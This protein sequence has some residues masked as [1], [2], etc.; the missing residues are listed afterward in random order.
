[1]TQV[2]WIAVFALTCALSAKAE[3][4]EEAQAGLAAAYNDFYRALRSK[5]QVSA[6]EAE[7]IA[8]QI[9][10]PA[11]ARVAK[12]MDED[13][14]QA[15]ASPQTFSSGKFDKAEYRSSSPRSGERAPAS[16][17]P[18]TPKEEIVIDGSNIPK[19]LEFP[20]KARK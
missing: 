15:K 3:S 12:A 2:G 6:E 1:M 16:L 11:N 7:K 9:L 4:Y 20:G 19:E 17:L 18:A 8:S 13:A 10:A 14:K 5:P